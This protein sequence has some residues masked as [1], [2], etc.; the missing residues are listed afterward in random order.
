MYVALDEASNL[1]SKLCYYADGQ[2]S[3]VHKHNHQ[4]TVSS[5]FLRCAVIYDIPDS[6]SQ[7][8]KCRGMEGRFI[9]FYKSCDTSTVVTL[10]EV[11]VY[12]GRSGTVI[13]C[14]QRG[15]GVPVQLSVIIGQLSD[16]A[17]AV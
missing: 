10:C 6:L 1:K 4:A 7:T 3:H 12:G 15:M 14:R 8:V 13:T 9:N 5:L 2:I 17:G 16:S 11:K